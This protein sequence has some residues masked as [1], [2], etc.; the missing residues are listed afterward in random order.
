MQKGKLCRRVREIAVEVVQQV[1][2]VARMFSA[3]V[4]LI[5]RTG[6]GAGDLAVPSYAAGDLFSSLAGPGLRA[7]Q[8]IDEILVGFQR[9]RFEPHVHRGIARRENPFDAAA[10]SRRFELTRV[11]GQD[12]GI[13]TIAKLPR[14]THRLMALRWFFWIF[15][16]G[17]R[18]YFKVPERA[19]PGF[20]RV[21]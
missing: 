17:L 16:D 18:R 5:R 9:S 14:R 1:A 3:D 10:R 21:R 13:V 6:G 12:T 8:R 11:D 7:P 4:A 15:P 2:V 20:D 19:A